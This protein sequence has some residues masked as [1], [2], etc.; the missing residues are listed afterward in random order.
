MHDAQSATATAPKPVL[1]AEY[2]P[3]AFLVDS[4]ALGFVLDEHATRVTARLT[5]RRNPAAPPG[6]PL[7][8]DGEALTLVR[9]A[10]DGAGPPRDRL[11]AGTRRRWSSTPCPTPPRWRS[12]P[13][14]PP[15]PTPS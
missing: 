10:L 6:A 5:L 8:L 7:H 14:S 15:P 13:A 11:S 1:L 12:R 9:L 3:P 2:Q 4:V